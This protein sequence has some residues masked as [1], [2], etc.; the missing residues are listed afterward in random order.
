MKYVSVCPECHAIC[1][2][3]ESLNDI[4]IEFSCEKGGKNKID[5]FSNTYITFSKW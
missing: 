3:Y 5:I 2:E 1:E 4:P